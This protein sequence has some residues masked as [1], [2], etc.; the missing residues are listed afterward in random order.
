V[1][2]WPIARY[3]FSA[4]TVFLALFLGVLYLLV[5]VVLAV[6]VTRGPASVSAV[7]VAG[8]VLHWL[9]VGYG[10]SSV[11]VLT[12]MVVHGRTRREFLLQ[13]PLFQV[14]TAAVLAALVTGVYAAEAVLYRAA[15]WQQQMQPHRVFE[16]GDHLMIFLS[17]TSMLAVCMMVGTFTGVWMARW[18]GSGAVALIPAALLLVYAGG[19]NGFFSLPFARFP[20]AGAPLLV[21]VTA[22]IFAVGWALLWAAGRDLPLRNRVAG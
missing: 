8:Q 9:A 14:V 2:R 18:E 19:V 22:G 13:H 17:Y 5:A 6:A 21:A 11:A 4:H 3:L 20:G 12:T 1:S 10:Y 16:A 7:D 15:G